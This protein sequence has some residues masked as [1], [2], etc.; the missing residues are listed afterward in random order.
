MIIPSSSLRQNIDY[1]PAFIEVMPSTSITSRS[2]K[3]TQSYAGRHLTSTESLLRPVDT[4]LIVISDVERKRV[5]KESSSATSASPSSID[6][7]Y[8]L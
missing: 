7:V 2:Q 1:D 6:V 3:Y 5:E 4:P 8:L